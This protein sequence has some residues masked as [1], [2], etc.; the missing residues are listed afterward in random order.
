MGVRYVAAESAALLG[1][2]SVNV[3]SARAMAESAEAACD[4]L[5]GVLGGGELSGEGFA[6]ARAM[7]V[8]AI[9]PGLVRVK[10]FIGDAEAD[11]AVYREA[12]GVVSRYG[13][14]DE[15]GLREQLVLV[16][17]QR[18]ATLRLLE[19][20]RVTVAA[21]STLPVV[22]VSLESANARLEVVV[23]GLD[24]HL[25]EL[26]D[27][28]NALEMFCCRTSGLFD[29]RFED[30]VEFVGGY[31][32]VG[33]YVVGVADGGVDVVRVRDFLEGKRFVRDARGRVRWQGLGRNPRYVYDRFGSVMSGGRSN[34]LYRNGENFNAVTGQ[35]I[36]TYRQPFKA[37]GAGF[38]RAAVDTGRDFT[39]WKGMSNLARLSKGAGA[40]G[41][42]FTVGVNAYDTF[43]DGVKSGVQVRDFAIN[44]TVDLG[45]AAAAAG[46]GAFFGSFF[47]PPAGTVV[48]AGIGLFANFLMNA[49]IP[50][51]GTSVVDAA[52]D[53]AKRAWDWV[54]GRLW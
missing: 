28:L 20:N 7:F 5:V 3:S 49:K 10:G 41:S 39:G 30:V 52:K 44:T 13:V 2:L 48:G 1:V 18:D 33:G 38:A 47:L 15:D 24:D 32:A 6:G 23:A 42:L 40:A 8:E 50:G 37:A 16:R 17:A 25:R 27:K 46:V 26:E 4:R 51:V 22:A 19:Q 29:A 21:T 12:D 54:A 14:L 34:H 36:D 31:P 43:H 11:V 35:R 53:G 45:S 9:M